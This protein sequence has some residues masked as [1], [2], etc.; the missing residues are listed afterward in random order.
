MAFPKSSEL[1]RIRKKLEKENAVRLETEIIRYELLRTCFS[2]IEKSSLRYPA[3]ALVFCFRPEPMLRLTKL[4]YR[5]RNK[6]GKVR[7]ALQWLRM[8]TPAAERYDLLTTD[9]EISRPI[10]K[11]SGVRKILIDINYIAGFLAGNFSGALRRYTDL[12]QKTEA[13]CNANNIT[14]IVMGPSVRSGTKMER[15]LSKRFV[16]ALISISRNR[17]YIHGDLPSTDACAMYF[18]GGVYVSEHYHRMIAEK[19]S[20]HIQS[21]IP[22]PSPL[23]SFTVV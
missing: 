19:T 3:D 9:P 13:H 20:E 18:E 1:N 10:R 17:R 2:K 22:H 15:W 14:F 11:A 8:Q 12:M 6:S 4:Y 7:R 21:V 16:A 5:Y 23:K